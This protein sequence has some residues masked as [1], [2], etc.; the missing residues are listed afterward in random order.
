MLVVLTFGNL[1]KD[2][3]MA[4]DAGNWFS[5]AD[6]FQKVYFLA[7]VWYCMYLRAY[8]IHAP[9]AVRTGLNNAHTY[10]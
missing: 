8:I 7:Y 6:H 1:C 5:L 10:V 3:A 9:R 2:A 4:G